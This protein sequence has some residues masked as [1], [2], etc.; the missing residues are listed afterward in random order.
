MSN[1]VSQGA[2]LLGT[3]PT[4]PVGQTVKAAL[5]VWLGVVVVLSATGAFVGAAGKPPLPVFAGA[6]VPVIL[7]AVAWRISQAFRDFLLALD[8]RLIVAMQA[9][10]YA[11]FGFIALYANHVLPGLFAW[12]AG[13]GDMAIGVAAP[14]WIAALIKNPEAVASPRFRLWHALGILD[15]VIAF[16][17]ATISSMTLVTDGLPSMAPI[18][19]L[20]LALIPAFMVPLFVM[21][22][23]VALMQSKRARAAALQ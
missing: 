20:P 12:P 9:W 22:H 21:L 17:T 19:Q 18:T 15:F 8:V 7:F 23:I 11:G 2:T 13:L 6:V 1:S 10:R 14:L 16:T 5:A 4:P 3:G